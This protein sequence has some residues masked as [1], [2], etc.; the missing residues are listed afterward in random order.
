V[1]PGP[2]SDGYITNIEGVIGR[3]QEQIES[4]RDNT[5]DDAARKKAKNMLKKLRKV[6]FGQDKIKIIIEDPTGNSA[7]LSDKAEV[8]KLSAGQ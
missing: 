3:V 5:D 1:T 8:H 2:A 7:I 6:R 4:A